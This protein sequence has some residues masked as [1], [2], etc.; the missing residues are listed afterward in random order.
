MVYLYTKGCRDAVG[1]TVICTPAGKRPIFEAFHD[2]G[3]PKKD[4]TSRAIWKS[5]EQS[6]LNKGESKILRCCCLNF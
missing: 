4:G 1:A 3:K 2:N 5:I 6:P